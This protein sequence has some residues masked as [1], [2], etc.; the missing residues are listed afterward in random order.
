MLSKDR[1]CLK[2]L[3][4]LLFRAFVDHENNGISLKSFIIGVES[5]KTS[6]SFKTSF[7]LLSYLLP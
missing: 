7:R 3:L 4:T 2:H 5:F 1:M 6:L